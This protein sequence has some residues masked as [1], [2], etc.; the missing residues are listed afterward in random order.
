MT[1]LLQ[2]ALIIL[3]LTFNHFAA[4]AIWSWI[5][6]LTENQQ[7]AWAYDYTYD[8]TIG[9]WDEDDETINPCYGLTSCTV[10]IGHRH[11]AAGT[12]GSQAIRSWD[13]GVHKFLLSA[14]TMGELGREVKAIFSL[15]FTST[16][17]HNANS[18]TT[19]ECVGLF[20]AAGSNL[21]T[22]NGEVNNASFSG[23]LLLPGS[24]CGT[25]PAPSG[26]C[27]F[28]QNDITLEHGTL[29][30]S[31]LEGHSASAEV[32]ISCT[33]EKTIQV[34]IYSADGVELRG[35]GSLFSELYINDSALSD[36]GFTLEVQDTISVNVKSVLRT[37]GTVAAG[38][39]SGS[40]VMLITIE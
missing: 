23:H 6:F 16:A 20:Y 10:F 17:R 26:T 36:S 9:G 11:D 22:N 34:Y 35:D 37:N 27:D 39:F 12:S 18:V 7:S 3:G 19:E 5:N 8:F 2:I 15:P 21:G 14:K 13:A 25:A 4:A 29:T 31:E 38:D 1:K 24:I 30:R 40:T 28:D 32:N 33:S